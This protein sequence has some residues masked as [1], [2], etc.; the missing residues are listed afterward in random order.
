MQAAHPFADE[1]KAQPDVF[2]HELNE[3]NREQLRGLLEAQLL[4]TLG[5][6]S[7]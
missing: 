7:V 1:L 2:V 5:R 4:S 3:R 6:F